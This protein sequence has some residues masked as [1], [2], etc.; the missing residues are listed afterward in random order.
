M[1]NTRQRDGLACGIGTTAMEFH[2]DAGDGRSLKSRGSHK[3]SIVSPSHV[4]MSTDSKDADVEGRIQLTTIMVR[5]IRENRIVVS[6]WTV[7]MVTVVFL[8]VLTIW[9]TV[10]NVALPDRQAGLRIIAMLIF[11]PL[12]MVPL[13]AESKYYLRRT[14]DATVYV[15]LQVVKTGLWI[16]LLLILLAT[17]S[18]AEEGV[19]I[20][21][22]A[23]KNLS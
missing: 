4:G 5:N 12:L 1:L 9:A 2:C 13:L 19:L 6:M 16:M 18:G 20:F 17:V 11:A 14:L 8:A 10:A 3:L 23:A 21:D 22:K 7:Q 15:R